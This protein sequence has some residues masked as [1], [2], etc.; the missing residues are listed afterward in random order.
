MTVS[1][2]LQVLIA[3][4]RAIPCV[5]FH[6]GYVICVPSEQWEEQNAG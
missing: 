5:I 2:P 1:S 4:F 3:A 6:S